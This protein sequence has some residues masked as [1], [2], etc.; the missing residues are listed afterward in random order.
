MGLNQAREDLQPACGHPYELS[1]ADE[2]FAALDGRL[3]TADGARWHLEVLGIHLHADTCWVQVLALGPANHQLS[4][5][6]QIDPAE[7]AELLNLVPAWLA[8]QNSRAIDGFV[9]AS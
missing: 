4:S 1:R 7:P 3:V 9:A 8:T 5:T 6:F 2:L